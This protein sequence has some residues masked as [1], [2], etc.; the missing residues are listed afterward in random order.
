MS[1]YSNLPSIGPTSTSDSFTPTL[2]E[3]LSSNEINDLLPTSIRYILT[4]YWIQNHPSRFNIELNNWFDE[5]FHLILKST[6]QWYHLSKYDST[7]INKFY[8]L[9]QYN[10]GSIL[11]SNIS[12]QFLSSNNNNNNTNVWPALLR[13]TNKQRY[14]LLAQDVLIPYLNEKLLYRYNQWVRENQTLFH[15]TTAAVHESITDNE[16]RLYNRLMFHLKKLFIKWYPR[17][18]R[19]LSLIDLSIKLKFLS[20]KYGSHT[21]L[22]EYL[23]NIQYTRCLRP[24]EPLTTDNHRKNKNITPPF[25][26][27]K[28][29]KLNNVYILSRLTH[30]FHDSIQKNLLWVGSTLF[31]SFIFLLKVY[32]W[33]NNE[34]ITSKIT[35]SLNQ[36]NKYVPKPPQVSHDNINNGNSKN[37]NEAKIKQ[38][39]TSHCIICHNVIANPCIIETGCIAC[40]PCMVQ[41]L[42][43]HKGKCPLTGKTLLGYNENDPYNFGLSIR[44]LLI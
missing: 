6:I 31:P 24:L 11:N 23:F 16:S 7:F 13:L 40:Y 19:L 44:K 25:E 36:L 5:W 27:N 33:W 29:I 9:Q 42:K 26:I 30:L 1:F 37:T 41:Y 4:K 39:D 43:E 3:I 12:T 2:F 10:G 15:A 21:T 28:K 14:V 38:N 22:L 17:I 8:G 18:I 34:N 35:N 32:Q 20:R